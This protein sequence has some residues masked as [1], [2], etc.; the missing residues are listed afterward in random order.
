MLI[1][2]P[3]IYLGKEYTFQVSITGQVITKSFKELSFEQRQCHLR[4]EISNP[5]QMK[6]YNQVN[7]LFEC[8]MKLANE[9][10]QC[11]TWELPLGKENLPECDVFGRTC[12]FD[13]LSASIEH[14]GGFC[15]K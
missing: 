9:I 7:C 5:S 6:V 10:C 14:S 4:D 11:Q 12:I 15:Q 8:R 13:I 2:K 3:M 1:I